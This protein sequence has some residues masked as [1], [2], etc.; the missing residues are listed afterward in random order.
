LG[1]GIGGGLT[2]KRIYFEMKINGMINKYIN[3]NYSF[4]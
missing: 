3:K 4:S 2:G 1:L